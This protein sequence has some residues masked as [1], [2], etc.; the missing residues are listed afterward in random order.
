MDLVRGLT[1]P[2]SGG[3]RGRLVRAV[4]GWIPI[5]LGIGW[6]VGELTGCGRFAAT[7][8]PSVMPLTAAGQGIVLLALVAVPE[9]AAIAAGA[10]LVLLGAAVGATLILS[11]TGTAADEGSRRAALGALLVVSWLSGLA[12]AAVRRL[13]SG[14][15]SSRPVS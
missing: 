7:C 11:A 14:S 2:R 15:R 4:L 9:V 6:L 3:F 5:A 12:I 8:D 1:D 10:A 13:R